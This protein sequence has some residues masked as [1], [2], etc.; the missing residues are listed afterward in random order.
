MIDAVIGKVDGIG[1]HDTRQAAHH[2]RPV[3]GAHDGNLRVRRAR[4]LLTWRA[5][6]HGRACTSRE[7]TEEKEGQQLKPSNHG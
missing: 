5:S 2:A 6:D 3:G 1:V 4:G 7:E